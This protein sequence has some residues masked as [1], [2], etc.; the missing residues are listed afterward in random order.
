MECNF[1]EIQLRWFALRGS[2]YSPNVRCHG[3]SIL[4]MQEERI[5]RVPTQLVG[6]SNVSGGTQPTLDVEKRRAD[7]ERRRPNSLM[8]IR[9]TR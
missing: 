3:S 7:G 1:R 4:F 8:S 9:Q 6:Y 5:T 2:L